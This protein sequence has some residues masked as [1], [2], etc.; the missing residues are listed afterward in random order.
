MAHRPKPEEAKGLPTGYADI[1]KDPNHARYAEVKAKLEAR[2]AWENEKGH[3][4]PPRDAKKITNENKATP[5]L[6]QYIL[7]K[8]LDKIVRY[9]ESRQRHAKICCSY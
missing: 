7:N 2:R 1:L 6:E 8:N 5:N 9:Q 4:E 3:K